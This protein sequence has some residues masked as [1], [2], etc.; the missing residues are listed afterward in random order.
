MQLS[1]RAI[2]KA[3]GLK[4]YIGSPCMRGH[5]GLRYAR[6]KHCAECDRI[7]CSVNGRAKRAANP[8]EQR[9]RETTRKVYKAF[10]ITEQQYAGM[11]SKQQGCCATCNRPLVSRF[12]D[13]RDIRQHGRGIPRDVACV[14]HDHDTNFIRGLL[15]VDC[16]VGLGNFRD[17]KQV[18]LQAARYLDASRTAQAQPVAERESVSE[19]EPGNRDLDSNVCRGNRREQLS[20]FF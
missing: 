16:N 1:E 9:R 17:D 13:T 5:N 10:G 12:D 4:T 3:A 18:L 11:F 8:R 2:A 15:C 19:I 7:R 20:P 14:D 6:S